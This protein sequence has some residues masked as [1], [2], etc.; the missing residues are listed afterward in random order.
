MRRSACTRRCV[1][2]MRQCA[3]RITLVMSQASTEQRKHLASLL[4]RLDED[5]SR[6]HAVTVFYW[7]GVASGW[8]MR[9]RCEQSPDE[10]LALVGGVT[11]ASDAGV[12]PFAVGWG[13]GWRVGER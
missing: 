6:A 12:D 4:S 9:R 11:V 2:S 5:M 8:R 10:I 1:R 7:A 13:F 3:V